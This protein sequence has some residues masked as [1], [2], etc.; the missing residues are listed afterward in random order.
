MTSSGGAFSSG[1][2]FFQ[3]LLHYSNEH[4][5]DN[6]ELELTFALQSRAADFFKN[7]AGPILLKSQRYSGM[8]DNYGH[9]QPLGGPINRNI[10]GTNNLPG[11][12]FCSPEFD[13]W[14]KSTGPVKEE[15]QNDIIEKYTNIPNETNE[16]YQNH[17]FHLK[18]NF[19]ENFSVDSNDTWWIVSIIALV[20]IIV[21]IGIYF[22]SIQE[23]TLI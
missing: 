20:I 2:S 11:T 5:K 17:N 6:K 19:T 7:N 14:G 1:Q 15:Q 9:K 13:F 22:L 8:Q 3:D 4:T 10:A 21:C 12:G 16:N 18:E 23:K